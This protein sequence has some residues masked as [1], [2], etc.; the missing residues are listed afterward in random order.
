MNKQDIIKALGEIRKAEKRKFN[1]SVDLIVNLK[2]FDIKKD[3]VNLMVSLPNK[4]KDYK[5]AAFLVDKSKFIDSIAKNE[6]DR[7]K[8]KKGIKKLVKAYDFFMAS[9]SL[10]PS[11][12]STFGKYLG[13]AGKMPNP[14]LGIV[15]S[16]TEQ[17][18]KD[19]AKK[20]EKI[21]KIKSKEPSL[22][23]SIGK[24]SMKDEEIADNIETA[25]NA[26][27]NALPNKKE[28]VKSA[29]VKLS[30]GKPVKLEF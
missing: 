30:M 24:E 27:L 28:N 12:A 15:K 18:I 4:I 9:A 21:L 11:I 3:S 7:Y 13:P 16:E 23:F 22:K 8:D 29:M 25:Y 10:M 19:T 14:Q 1:Q 17:D 6:F 5:I 20:F 26:I 2:N